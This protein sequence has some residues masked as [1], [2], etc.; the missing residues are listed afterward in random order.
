MSQK[1]NILHDENHHKQKFK[2]RDK[3]GLYEADPNKKMHISIQ[4]K[5]ATKQ[6][7]MQHNYQTPQVKPSY[8]QIKIRIISLKLY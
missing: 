4:R 8:I 5:K 2:L 6:D 7:G 1:T 3:S